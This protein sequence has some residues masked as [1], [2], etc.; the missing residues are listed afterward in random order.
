MYYQGKPFTGVAFD[1]YDESQ[2]LFEE[3]FK[4]GKLDGVFKEYH[5]NGELATEGAY[6]DGKEDGIFKQYWENGQLSSEKVYKEGILDGVSKS[7]LRDGQV[8][9]EQVW[10]DGQ[11]V[12]QAPI[13]GKSIKIG[14]LEVAQNDFPRHMNWNDAKKACAALGDG[15]RLPT[16][17][18]LNTLFQNKDKI[19]NF[20]RAYYWISTEANTNDAWRKDFSSGF[21]VE[22]STHE[23]KVHRVRAVRTF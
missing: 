22:E 21:Q 11:P 13:I 9:Y 5:E 14:S 4:N 2:L 15:W 16:L 12:N 19:G 1:M 18:E 8:Q 20:Q 17:D 3:Y 7:Y 10:K 6:K 23:L